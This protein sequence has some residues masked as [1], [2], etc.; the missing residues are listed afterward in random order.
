MKAPVSISLVIPVYGVERFIGRFAESVLGQSYPFIQFVFVN[1]GTKDSSI[2]ILESLI[3]NKFSH[4]RDK[5]VIVTKENAGLPAARKTGMEYATGDYVWHIDSDDWIEEGAVGKIAGC[6]A[7]TDADI[8]YF[9]FYKEY[10]DRTK[11]KVD[12]DYTV[13]EKAAYQRDMYNHRAHGCVWNKC[14]KR[15]LYIENEVH[16]PEYSY[17]EDT[18]LMSQLVGYA[19]SIVHLN[20]ALYHYRKDNPHAITRQGSQKRHREAAMNFLSLYEIYRDAPVNPVASIFDDIFYRAGA[21]SVIYGLGLFKEYP[22]LAVNIL[23]ARLKG[24]ADIWIPAQIVL[25][26]YSLFANKLCRQ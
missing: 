15:K 13:A 21:Y 25:K 9:N 19:D 12:K 18:F 5:I 24:R 3:D 14:V 8:I 2:Q 6:A 10:S 4:L 26:L 23:K 7:R 17:A 1:D 22:Y 11:L 16:F 20:E